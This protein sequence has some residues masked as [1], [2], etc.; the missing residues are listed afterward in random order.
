MEL[1]SFARCRPP[2]RDDAHNILLPL[3]PDH[4]DDAA[5]DGTNRDEPVFVDGMGFVED[6]QEVH[7]GREKLGGLLKGD[8]VL[9]LISAVLGFIPD[10]LHKLVVQVVL[11]S[12]NDL[13]GPGCEVQVIEVAFQRPTW[14]LRLATPPRN[15]CSTGNST[16]RAALGS[17]TRATTEGPLTRP[18]G[19][20]EETP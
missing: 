17:W 6:L 3:G 18:V 19:S 5:D 1:G 7:S 4:Q 20:E 9:D 10:D 14:C 13:P 15:A 2:S 11:E 16:S 12:V 8:S